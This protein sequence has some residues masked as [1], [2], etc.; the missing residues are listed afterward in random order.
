MNIN[1]II[2]NTKRMPILLARTLEALTPEQRQAFVLAFSSEVGKVEAISKRVGLTPI[3]R[4]NFTKDTERMV[5]SL[6]KRK[7]TKVKSNW[8]TPLDP[9]LPQNWD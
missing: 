3:T 6:S 4:P 2:K 8:G 9:T 7:S 5:T 1:D